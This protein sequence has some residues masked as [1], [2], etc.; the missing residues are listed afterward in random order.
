M[1]LI[2][3]FWQGCKRRFNKHLNLLDYV[4][5]DPSQHHLQENNANISQIQ[6]FTRGIRFSAGLRDDDETSPAAFAWADG[7]EAGRRGELCWFFQRAARG[8]G[9]LLLLFPSQAHV[10]VHSTS[11][12][13]PPPS[14]PPVPAAPLLSLIPRRAAFLSSSR[15]RLL[16]KRKK[17]QWNIFSHQ[18]EEEQWTPRSS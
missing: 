13:K 15:L 9:H 1:K 8:R 3:C 6:V 5:V 2:F 16:C 11:P 17:N 12:S 14:S 4:N 10:H 18:N 7:S